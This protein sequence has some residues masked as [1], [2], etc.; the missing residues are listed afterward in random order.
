MSSVV[1][2][3]K[4]KLFYH[5]RLISMMEGKSLPIKDILLK[6]VKEMR[7]VLEKAKKEEIEHERINHK[8]NTNSTG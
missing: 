2:E 3:L 8:N 7:D 5:E 6:D 4:Q 1:K